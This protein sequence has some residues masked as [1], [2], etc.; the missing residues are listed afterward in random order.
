MSPD[1][2]STTGSSAARRDFIKA[3]LAGA[4]MVGNALSADQA[5][6]SEGAPQDESNTG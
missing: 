3:G 5:S 4:L 1:S 2:V 6:S